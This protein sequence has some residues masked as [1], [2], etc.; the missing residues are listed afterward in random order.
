MKCS[1][2]HPKQF[3]LGDVYWGNV[4]WRPTGF[5][6]LQNRTGFWTGRIFMYRSV[7]ICCQR[8]HH[9][10]RAR[11]RSFTERRWNWQ[12][13]RPVFS[14]LLGVAWCDMRRMTMQRPTFH[15]GTTKRMVTLLGSAVPIIVGYISVRSCG[16][17]I[18]YP[19]NPK[20]IPKYTEEISKTV[21]FLVLLKVTVPLCWLEAAFEGSPSNLKVPG[22]Q[23]KPDLLRKP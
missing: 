13:F 11:C 4:K 16:G 19:D 1:W 2:N 7:S 10:S 18:I 8:S 23:T 22:F 21:F 20:C 3:G 9:R 15:G 14:A 17:Y 6:F 12:I 5:F